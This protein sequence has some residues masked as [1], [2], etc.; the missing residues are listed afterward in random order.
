MTEP[1]A[2]R[3]FRPAKS[4]PEDLNGHPIGDAAEPDGTTDARF[5]PEELE[6]PRVPADV[7]A[8]FGGPAPAPTPAGPGKGGPPPKA[9]LPTADEPDPFNPESLRVNQDFEAAAGVR[10]VLLSVPVRKP[11]NSWFVRAH[12]DRD[13][14][15]LDTYVIEL[16][17]DREVYLVDRALWPDLA[18]EVTF[19]LKRLATAINRQNVVFL[20]EL[21]LPR[22][23]GRVDEWTRTA[24]EGLKRAE[25]SWVRLSANMSLGAYDLGIGGPDLS[26]PQWPE[27][28]FTELLKLAFRDRF[29]NDLSHPVL[30][31]LRGEV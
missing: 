31:R 6:S 22:P 21:N 10:K 14:Y 28:S 16:K 4:R 12:P 17:E 13:R 30:R 15:H 26:E 27:A 11:H 7:E 25:K 24:L 18:G 29:I 9:S 19:K 1:N 23:D 8:E 5:D 3:R 2:A 20:W